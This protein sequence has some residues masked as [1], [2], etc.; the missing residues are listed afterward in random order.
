MSKLTFGICTIYDDVPR[1]KA[2]IDSVKALN[3]PKS[4]ILVVGP[5]YEELQK[6]GQCYSDQNVWY[7]YNDK[8][9]PHKKNLI[10]K[11]SQYETL[12]LFHDYFLFDPRWYDGYKLFAAQYEWD[13]CCVPQE[14]MDGTRHFTDW[15]VWDHPTLPQYTSLSYLDWTNTK[16][17]YISG[18]FFMVKRNLLLEN[19]FDETLKPGDPE[20]VEWSLRVRDKAKII[21][22][23]CSIVRHNKKHRDCG[24]TG[25]PF[26]QWGDVNGK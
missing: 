11:L 19:P 9:T 13:I 26:Q 8:W 21:C 1:L 20:D 12:V 14:L 17:Q 18:G 24:R 10:A 22:N 4:E 2:V 3:V 16:Y 23:P 5:N 25:F 6:E 7:V 15:L